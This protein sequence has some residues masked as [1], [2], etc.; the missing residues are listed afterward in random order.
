MKSIALPLISLLL[1]MLA[2]SAQAASD[3][4]RL[5]QGCRELVSIYAKRGHMR[6]AAGLTTS[7]SE[8]LRAGYCRGVLDEFRRNRWEACAVQ[9]W[10]EQAQKIASEPMDTAPQTTTA[11]LLEQSCEI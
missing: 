5:I 3:S 1:C 8:A 9:D 7:V 10:F 6:L 11:E 4:E 2:Q